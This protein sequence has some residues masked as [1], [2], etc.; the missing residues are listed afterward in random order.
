MNLYQYCLNN[1]VNY[2]D[3]LG[4]DIWIGRGNRRAGGLNN[5]LHYKFIIDVYDPVYNKQKRLIGLRKTGL[6]AAFSF[7]KNGEYRWPWSSEDNWLWFDIDPSNSIWEGQV[8]EDEYCKDNDIILAQKRTKPIHDFNHL[9][10]LRAMAAFAEIGIAGR[11][12]YS[13]SYNCRTFTNAMFDL[14]PGEEIYDYR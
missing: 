8:Y 10:F 13:G 12:G 11:D 3:P 7:G 2:I 1:P 5:G 14:L 4:M 6:K 9:N